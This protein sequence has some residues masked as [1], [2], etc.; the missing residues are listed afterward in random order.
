MVE[1]QQMVFDLVKYDRKMRSEEQMNFKMMV[2]SFKWH[3]M[4]VKRRKR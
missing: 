3:E 4:T 1:I 2:D